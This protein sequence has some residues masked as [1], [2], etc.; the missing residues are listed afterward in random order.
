MQVLKL[1]ARDV[2]MKVAG[3][4]VKDKLLG[5][6]NVHQFRHLSPIFIRDSD[7]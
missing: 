4:G 1:G 3:L 7:I 5:K 2:P 6:E